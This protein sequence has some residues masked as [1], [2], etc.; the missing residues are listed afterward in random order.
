MFVGSWNVVYN[1]CI[2][3]MRE[4]KMTNK[5]CL[6]C[7]SYKWV[8]PE[9]SVFILTYF[10]TCLSYHILIHVSLHNF[11]LFVIISLYTNPY[12][13]IIAFQ[14]VGY[15]DLSIQCVI[16]SYPLWALWCILSS[17]LSP[18]SLNLNWCTALISLETVENISINSHAQDNSFS[19][20]AVV[21]QVLHPLFNWLSCAVNR[22]E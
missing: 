3:C 7:R 4:I 11:P 17:S 20:S 5:C 14:H 6:R 22:E 15:A 18:L 12:S 10:N 1:F 16:I 2:G 21:L 19:G 9:K 8:N 13:I